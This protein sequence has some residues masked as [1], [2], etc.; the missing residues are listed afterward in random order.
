MDFLND[1]LLPPAK[2]THA[3]AVDKLFG[4]VNF[5]SVILI[6]GITIA[7]LYFVYKYYRKSENEVTPIIRQ[8]VPLEVAWTIIP[9]FLVFIVFGWGFKGYMELTQVPEDAYEIHVTAQRWL[10]KFEYPNGA[11]TT[12]ELHVPA[13]RPVKLLMQSKS[14]DVIHS[15]YVPDYRI[16]KDVLPNQY[17]QVWFNVKEPGE[18]DLF[19]AEYCGTGHSDMTGTVIAHSEDEYEEWLADAGSG[20]MKDLPPVERGEKLFTQ[21]AC[22]TCH[23]LDG[24]RKTGPTVKGLFGSEEEMESGQ[25]ITVDENYLR[26]SIL[27]PNAKIVAGYAAVMPS[28]KGQLSDDQIDAIIEYIKAQK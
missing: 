20:S 6:V 14:G 10:W 23:S 12:N 3:D 7:V 4:F 1:F 11:T 22:Q 13:N 17:T 26:E 8:N 16:K 27:N 25:T 18:S 21:N 19:C 28:F 5:V 2:S 9:L 24:S 15:F